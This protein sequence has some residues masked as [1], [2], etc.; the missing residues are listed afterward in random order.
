MRNRTS[1]I[2]LCS[3]Y[4]ISTVMGFYT[5][6]YWAPLMHPADGSEPVIAPVVADRESVSSAAYFF[7][8]ILTMTGAMLLLMKYRLDA[9][10]KIALF[11]SFFSG[12]LFTSVAFL[13]IYGFIIPF[14]SSFFLFSGFRSHIIQ[15]ILLVITLSGVG[16]VL[17]ASLGIVPAF[18][19][20]LAMSAYDFI[21]VFVTKHM[22]S[23]AEGAQDKYPLMFVIPLG[24]RYMHLGAGDIAIPIT[25]SVSIFLGQGIAYAIP[26]ALG[27]TIG[28]ASLIS[29]IEQRK[30]VTLPALP[31]LI[32]GQIIGYL[33]AVAI[34]TLL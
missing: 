8:V 23:L 25:L 31:P 17:G 18:I 2:L 26:T 22:V 28:I 21:A 10:I 11:I 33:I 5:A 7:A 27:A 14:I 20:V 6:S 13:G 24:D 1:V 4:L 9:V 19:L 34:H 12:T 3:I 30:G 32:A 16:A 29:Y 15:D